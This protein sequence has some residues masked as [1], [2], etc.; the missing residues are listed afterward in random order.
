[1]KKFAK[2]FAFAVWVAGIFA[3]FAP[4]KVLSE[5]AVPYPEG[6]REWT[7]VKSEIVGPESPIYKKYGGIHHIYAN[8]K[9]VEGLNKGKFAD[10]AVFVFD[11][12]ETCAQRP[13][14]SQPRGGAASSTSCTRTTP[15]SQRQAVGGS[16]NSTLTA[17]PNVS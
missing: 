13:A 8:P 17:T 7:H 5:G 12:L 14:A 1:M 3:V 4:W 11:Q 2:S 16:R 10:G 6:Y 9:A 15:D